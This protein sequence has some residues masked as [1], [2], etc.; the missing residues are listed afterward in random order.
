MQ[1]DA[2]ARDVPQCSLIV[3][4]GPQGPSQ[5]RAAVA[6]WAAE[7][8]IDR[9]CDDLLLVVSE[10]VTNAIRHGTPPVRLSVCAEARV[11]IVTVTDAAP[12]EPVRRGVADEAEGGRGLLLIDLLTERSGVRPEPPGK[13]VWA[14]VPRT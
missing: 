5:A 1:D 3:D 9:L 10:L 8:G 12:S 6:R 4:P 2:G 14:E 7:L 11:V 13:A